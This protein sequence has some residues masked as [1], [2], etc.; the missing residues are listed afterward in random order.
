MAMF[1]KGL[2]RL[3]PSLV[4]GLFKKALPTAGLSTLFRKGAN[5]IGQGADGLASVRKILN[6]PTVRMGANKL[7]LDL[8]KVSKQVDKVGN[9]LEIAKGPASLVK[10]V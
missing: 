6:D 7:G 5:A 10:Y 9:V 1:A 2:G 3:M 4:G 8:G